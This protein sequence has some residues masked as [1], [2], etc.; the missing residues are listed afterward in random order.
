MLWILMIL[1][2]GQEEAQQFLELSCH[3]KNG[4]S[5]GLG[6]V[7]ENMWGEEALVPSKPLL[8]PQIESISAINNLKRI[9]RPE[10]EFYLIGPYD[11]SASL[12]CDGDFE[13]D[14]FKAA[15]EKFNSLVAPS[16]RAVHIPKDVPAHIYNYC[17]VGMISVGMDTSSIIESSK[18]NLDAAKNLHIHTD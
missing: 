6:L 4:G 13:N 12:S 2:P 9:M 14:K 11:L 8:I 1:K 17:D 16:E 10:F 7:R 18:I 15:I 5:R 3:Y